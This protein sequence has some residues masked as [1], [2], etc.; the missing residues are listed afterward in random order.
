MPRA[1][2]A[3]SSRR[4][5]WPEPRARRS[6]LAQLTDRGERDAEERAAPA[7]HLGRDLGGGGFLRRHPGELEGVLARVAGPGD[8][9]DVGQRDRVLALIRERR[10]P[11]L[12]YTSPSP[13]DGLLS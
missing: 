3:C 13:R 2:R 10:Q 12:L 4:S 9:H 8:G 7:L 1:T 11:C 6:L 5:G